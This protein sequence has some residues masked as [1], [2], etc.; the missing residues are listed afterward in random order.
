MSDDNTNTEPDGSVELQFIYLE[1]GTAQ[2]HQVLHGG[3][4]RVTLGFSIDGENN[5]SLIIGNLPYFDGDADLQ[6]NAAVELIDLIKSL[7]TSEDVKEA[8]LENMEDADDAEEYE[9]DDI[10]DEEE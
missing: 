6:I 7:V 4:S 10:E 3:P 2:L 9:D 5:M 1:S 8:I